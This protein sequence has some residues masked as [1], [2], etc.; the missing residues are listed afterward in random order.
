MNRATLKSTIRQYD[1]DKWYKG[2]FKK[3]SMC[4]YVMEKKQIGYELCYRNNFSSK[5]YAR[6]RI[7]AL[8]LEVHKGRGLEN[9]N[10]LC[11]LCGEEKEDLTHF[12]CICSKLEQ[13]RNYN[14]LN[15]DITNHEESIRT[16]LFRNKNYIEISKMLKNIWELRKNK[17]KEQKNSPQQDQANNDNH[18]QADN[19]I[20]TPDYNTTQPNSNSNNRNHQTSKSPDISLPLHSSRK[21]VRPTEVGKVPKLPTPSGQVLV[22]QRRKAP[23]GLAISTEYEP[24]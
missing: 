20:D 24:P 14:Y 7:N 13:K 8:Q 4:F 1:T 19:R 21:I 22:P 6:A 15:R 11:K 3:S 9:F 23:Y 5:I 16:L 2:L 12:I 17:L 10:D 18:N